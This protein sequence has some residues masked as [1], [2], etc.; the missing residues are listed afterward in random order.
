MTNSPIHGRSLHW[1]IAWLVSVVMVLFS[2]GYGTYT[3]IEQSE[4]LRDSFERQMRAVA[5]GLAAASAD[6]LVRDDLAS[7]EVLA[8]RAAAYPGIRRLDVVDPAGKRLTTVIADGKGEPAVRFEGGLVEPPDSPHPPIGYRVQQSDHVDRFLPGMIEGEGLLWV[9]IRIGEPIGWV[10][11]ELSIDEIHDA[12]AHVWEDSV[13]AAILGLGFGVG[14]LLLF[15][16]RP[17]RALEE[18]AHFA[19]RMDRLSGEQMPVWQGTAEVRIL[20][21]ALNHASGKLLLQN[22]ELLAQQRHLQQQALELGEARDHAEAASQAKSEFLANMSHEIRTPMNGVLGMAELLADTPLTAEQNNYLGMLKGSGDGLLAIINDILDFSKIEAGKLTM[23]V[24]EFGVAHTLRDTMQ[25]LSPRADEKGIEML[26]DIDDRVPERIVGDP[27]RLRQIVTNLVGNAIK[28]TDAGEVVV[29][30]SL[31]EDDAGDDDNVTLQV[32]VADT[33]IGIP[34]DKLDAIFEKFSQA[35]ASTTRR[36]GGT[37]LGLSISRCLVEM[38]HGHIGVESTPEAGSVFRFTARFGRAAAA[39][40]RLSP[41][42]D[43]AG[44][45]VLVADD[46]ATNRAILDAALRGQGM[47]PTLAEDGEAALAALGGEDNDRHP[48]DFAILDSQMP[49]LDGYGVVEQL[50]ARGWTAP[51]ALVMLTSTGRRGDGERCRQLKI[52]GYLTK[53][54]GRERL[55]ELLRTINGTSA[56]AELVTHHVIEERT[57]SLHVLVAEDNPVNQKVAG[58]LLKKQGHEFTLAGNGRIAVELS[59]AAPFD[60]VLMDVQMPEMGG[61]EATRLIRRRETEKGLPRLPIVGL[62]ANAMIGDRERALEAGMD[63]YLTKPLRAEALR[64]ALAMIGG[65]A[66]DAA[67]VEKVGAGA[68]APPIPAG[69]EVDI[70]DLLNRC[71]GDMPLVIELVEIFMTDW[72]QRMADIGAALSAEDVQAL[73]RAAHAA[74]GTLALYTQGTALDAVKALELLG[75]AGGDLA[76]AGPHHARL[77]AESEHLLTALRRI[78]DGLREELQSGNPRGKPE[79]LATGRID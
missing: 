10:R 46:N 12:I 4:V 15:L 47:V 53:P 16:Y 69:D 66:R 5:E 55:F 67:A 33:G 6:A 42:V 40:D 17:V 45:R 59:A 76:A 50:R 11:L 34:A 27:G 38:M 1:Q 57:K 23:E 70:A 26:Y 19:A 25:A 31:V 78:L 18:T 39:P 65:S 24:I 68:T 79:S 73:S 61:I 21:E 72:P 3:A 64:A 22:Q 56:S 13:V 44:L 71:G 7:L 8:L 32:K 77:V 36:Y 74:K 29:S 41:S 2:L 58:A 48:F 30:V 37:G 35:D 20:G 54:V 49:R 9:Q 14:I 63:D 60:V 75:R 28:F 52:A 43:L 62:S 51:T